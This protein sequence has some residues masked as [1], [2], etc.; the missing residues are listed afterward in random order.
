MREGLSF[1]SLD[2]VYTALIT[3]FTEG[4]QIEETVFVRLLAFQEAAGVT[5]VV[6]CGTNGEGASLTVEERKRLYELASHQRGQ[7]KIIAGTASCSLPEVLTLAR[8]AQKVGCDAL[9][10]VPPFF[11]KVLSL[12]GLLSFYRAVLEEVELPVIL[13]HIPQLTGV[14]IEPELVEALLPYPNL[15]GVKDS[16]GNLRRLAAYLRFAP[17]LRVFIG[18]EER[19]ARALQ[20]G[21]AGTISGAANA[22]PEWVVRVWNTF[23]KGGDLLAAQTLLNEP[24]ALLRSLPYPTA[25]KYLLHLRGFPFSPV[26]PPLSDLK[27]E[28]RQLLPASAARWFG[29]QGLTSL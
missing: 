8:H 29:R 18:R 13:Y 20:R 14:P 24:L 1:F 16:E 28:Q 6:V 22:F 11:F 26:R 4:L 9:L 15:L 27:E 19:L 7:L 23:Q 5:G 25:S 2:G 17:R 3:P 10:V 12:P 21:A